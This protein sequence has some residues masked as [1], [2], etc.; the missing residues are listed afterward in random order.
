MSATTERRRLFVALDLP[1]EIRT[2]LHRWTTAAVAEAPAGQLRAVAPDAL[3]VTLCFLGSRPAADR[4]PIAAACQ[5]AAGLAAPRLST[6]RALWLPRRRPRALA[7]EL[8]DPSGAARTVQSVLARELH[9]GGWYEIET[10]PFLPHVTLARVRGRSG[11]SAVSVSD[12]PPIT[13]TA[14]H[15][16]L[17]A[18]QLGPGGS[19]YQRLHTVALSGS[20]GMMR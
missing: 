12:P 19:R 14:T 3:H 8:D 17:Y 4:E 5:L 9:A 7:I 16:T 20:S 15:T 6:G 11:V 1:E 18:S 13:F 10:R 2:E